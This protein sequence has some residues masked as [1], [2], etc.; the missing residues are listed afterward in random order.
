MISGQ[1]LVAKAVIA[2]CVSSFMM[3]DCDY[4]NTCGLSMI[5]NQVFRILI[6]QLN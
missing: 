1:A 5:S 4:S 3:F 2:Y 6:L